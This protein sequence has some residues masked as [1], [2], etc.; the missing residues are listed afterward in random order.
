MEAEL[1]VLLDR[2]AKLEQQLAEME[3]KKEST[4]PI[5]EPMASTSVLVTVSPPSKHNPKC[6]EMSIQFLDKSRVSALETTSQYGQF[7]KA[8]VGQDI[9]TLKMLLDDTEFVAE[10][11]T[12]TEFTGLLDNPELNISCKVMR[13]LNKFEPFRSHHMM[14]L[15][16]VAQDKILLLDSIYVYVSELLECKYHSSVNELNKTLMWWASCR[17]KQQYIYHAIW[18]QFVYHMY[19]RRD[20]MVPKMFTQMLLSGALDWHHTSVESCKPNNIAHTYQHF[21]PLFCDL[22]KI[23]QSPQY[24]EYIETNTCT[25]SQRVAF[26]LVRM[27]TPSEQTVLLDTKV[28]QWDWKGS[29]FYNLAFTGIS[30]EVFGYFAHIYLSDSYSKHT[31]VMQMLTPSPKNKLVIQTDD[32]RYDCSRAVDFIKRVMEYLSVMRAANFWID[33]RYPFSYPNTRQLFET[34]TWPEIM[35]VALKY[36]PIDEH[37]NSS[38]TSPHSVFERVVDNAGE[39]INPNLFVKKTWCS[40]ESRYQYSVKTV[41]FDEVKIQ[42]ALYAILTDKLDIPSDMLSATNRAKYINIMLTSIVNSINTHVA[43]PNVLP[44]FFVCNVR[45]L[46]IKLIC[47][48]STIDKTTMKIASEQYK[49][50]Q[51]LAQLCDL[52]DVSNLLSQYTAER[53][54]YIFSI[55]SYT[56]PYDKFAAIVPETK[57]F[58]GVDHFYVDGRAIME[59]YGLADFDIECAHYFNVTKPAL[60]KEHDDLVLAKVAQAIQNA[61]CEEIAP[62]A[63]VVPVE[64]VETVEATVEPVAHVEAV[65]PVEPVASVEPVAPSAP[66]DITTDTVDIA[67]APVVDASTNP[68]Y[69]TPFHDAFPNI[70]DLPSIPERLTAP[71]PARRMVCA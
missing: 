64:S 52:K 14:P 3:T 30:P 66:A 21:M 39:S 56:I 49:L 1:I 60:D 29:N 2:V 40:T 43:K 4:K 19:N 61:D 5:T 48:L 18:R 35:H 23:K 24:I 58:H 69:C 62:V 12:R 6:P 42:V 28:W 33:R 50:L 32:G 51:S 11:S 15:V 71:T 45:E 41:A 10:L 20:I 68:L 25:P 59:R 53:N 44:K 70:A 7:I 47:K 54:G 8:I 27:L 16:D 22:E 13:M 65:A 17:N 55:K 26:H 34:P 38:D 31:F 9:P 67:S 36:I 57:Y 63:P 37:R 46:L